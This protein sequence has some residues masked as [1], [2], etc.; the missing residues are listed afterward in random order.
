MKQRAYAK[1]LLSL[2]IFGGNGVLA[3]FIP[4]SSYQIVMARSAIGGLCLMGMVLACRQ[5]G[6]LLRDRK[7]LAFLIASGVC[8]SGSWLFIYEAF[9]EIGV[10]LATLSYYC[11]PVLVMALAP[12]LFGERLTWSKLLGF[13]AVLT[14]MVL[15]YGGDL[16][17]EGFTW[18]MACGLLSA[19][20]YAGMVLCNKKSAGTTGLQNAACQLAVACVVVMGFNLLRGTSL[21]PLD[22]KGLAAVLALGF[23]NTGLACWWY[24]SAMQ[25]L[26][27]QTISIC[28]YLEPVSALLLSAVLLG[29]RLTPIQWAGAALVLGGAAFAELV[30]AGEKST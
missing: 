29:E 6:G 21:A 23:L 11:G 10:S 3:S 22:G 1:Y 2:V 19:V 27:A 30:H 13:A 5:G 16:A 24:F 7:S 20:C 12:V 18:G 14:G 9:Q 4:W 17:V 26:S 28:G 8:M 15:L 25:E